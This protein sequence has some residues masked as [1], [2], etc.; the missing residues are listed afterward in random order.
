MDKINLRAVYAKYGTA[1]YCSHLDLMRTMQRAIKRSGIPIW[2]TEGFNP[3]IYLNFPVALPLGT[4]SRVEPM[5]F[6]IVEECDLG[7]LKDKLNSAMPSGLEIISIAPQ[8]MKNTDVFSA[9]YDVSVYADGYSG[10]ELA[11][12]M[13]EFLSADTIEIHKRSKKKGE[14]IVD[15]KPSVDIMS[16]TPDGKMLNMHMKLPAGNAFNLNVNAVLD[17]FSDKMGISLS[18]YCIKRTKISAEDGSDFV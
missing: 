16:M 15:I 12:K 2:Y 9:E 17:A 3:H 6:S 5:D 18:T 4:E 8:V 13:N 7:E 14:V 1:K 11:G 10:E